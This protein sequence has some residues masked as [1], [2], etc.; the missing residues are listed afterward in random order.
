MKR[1]WIVGVVVIVCPLIFCLA[2]AFAEGLSSNEDVL[3]ETLR[4]KDETVALLKWIGGIMVTGE[5]SAIIFLV[6]SLLELQALRLAE[7]KESLKARDSDRES[8]RLMHEADI[9]ARR[10]NHETDLVIHQKNHEEMKGEL[11]N[12][13]LVLQRLVDRFSEVQ[14]Q[15]G[16][17]PKAEGDAH[18]APA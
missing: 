4:T 18:G 12:Q 6:K 2:I 16:S 17:I 5:A 15:S 8:A 9:E 13:T 1:I 7:A 11:H 10:E 14:F 3:R